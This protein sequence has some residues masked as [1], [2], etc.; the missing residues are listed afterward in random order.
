[1]RGCKV[2]VDIERMLKFFYRVIGA[3]P[4][5]GHK[6]EREVR[7]WVAIVEYRSPDGEGFCLLDLRLH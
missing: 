5:G 3:P 1:V 6:A 4:G 7:P 2:W